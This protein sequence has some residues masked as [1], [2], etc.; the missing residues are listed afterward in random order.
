MCYHHCNRIARGF[1]LLELLIAIAVMGV[2]AALVI[3]TSSPSIHDQLL[4]AARAVAT[5]LAYGRSLAVANNDS[6]ALTF[7]TDNNRLILQHTG[8]NTALDILPRTAFSRPGD[9]AKQHILDLDDLPRVGAPVNLLTVRYANSSSSV[10]TT[11]LEFGP[12]GETTQ[13]TETTLWLT[14]GTGTAQR[15]VSLTV[16]PVTGLTTIGDYSGY[17]P[18]QPSGS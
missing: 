9:S 5:D 8:T 16:N 18:P 2:L 11:Q 1:T 6:Y 12:L 17:G 10:P 4:A 15:Y 3:P 14:A 7:E 13:A